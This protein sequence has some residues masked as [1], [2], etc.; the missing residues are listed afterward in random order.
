MSVPIVV[1]STK[2]AS[3]RSSTT[4]LCE[5]MIS[6]ASVSLMPGAA[7][8]SSSPSTRTTGGSPVGSC[9]KKVTWLRLPRGVLR[10]DGF[11]EG[12]HCGRVELRSR[13]TLELRHGAIDAEGRAVWPI[14]GHGVVGVADGDDPAGHRNL[15]ATEALRIALAVPALVMEAND[16][17]HGLQP[18]HAGQQLRAPHRVAPDE[19]L[20]LI[21]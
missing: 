10:L 3:E 17:G 18:G 20:L 2:V 12:L 16:R 21:V 5:S 6:W 11:D 4:D 13:A 8:M 7:A 14:G 1:E 9:S 15:L 19:R